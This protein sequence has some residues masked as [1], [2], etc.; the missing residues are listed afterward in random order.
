[1]GFS[2]QVTGRVQV[3]A[4]KSTTIALPIISGTVNTNAI[5]TEVVNVAATSGGFPALEEVSFLA[6]T[7]S[8]N[9]NSGNSAVISV[10]LQHANVNTSANF[11]NVPGT[12]PT[13]INSVNALYPATNINLAVGD[14]LLQFVRLQ[15]TQGA[16]G[17]NS[18]NAANV[19][20]SLAF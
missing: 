15:V 2:S 4:L 11:V 14:T 5:D 19:T 7:T 13:N 1:M 6:S 8:A 17:A 3:D 9:A 18:A 12:G 20:F 16:G 10:Q